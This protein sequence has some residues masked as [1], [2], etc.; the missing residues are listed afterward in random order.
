MAE[1]SKEN[2]PDWRRG[3]E[4]VCQEGS[5]LWQQLRQEKGWTREELEAQTDAVAGMPVVW[6]RQAMFEDLPDLP[7]IEELEALA[8]VYDTKPGELLD[9]CYEETG[10]MLREEEER[11]V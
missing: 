8:Q 7:T 9:R 6:Q 4:Y 11:D 3:A 2:W 10:R 5:P 1:H